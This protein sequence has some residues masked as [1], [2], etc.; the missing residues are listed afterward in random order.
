MVH[1]RKRPNLRQKL[2]ILAE[3]AQYD[4][5]LSSCNTGATGER[6]RVRDPN[7][8]LSK[9]IYPAAV[10]GKGTVY[11]LKVLQT[12]VC[13]NNCSYCG[14]AAN[15]DRHERMTL[16]PEELAAGFMMLHR[17]KKVGG[18]FLSSGVC[19]SP[20]SSMDSMIRT[21]EILRERYKFKDYLHLKIL[22]GA[23]F[24]VVEAAVRLAN[25]VSIN[26]E[27][28]TREQLGKIAPG[29]SFAEDLV[30]RMKWA[31]EMIRNGAKAKTQTT[32]FVVG[33]AGESDLDI[34]RTTDWLYREIYLFRTYFSAYQSLETPDLAE[35][36]KKSVLLREHRL[37]QTDFLL[38]GY[39][40]RLPDLIFDHNGDLPDHV[41]PK[42]AYAMMHPELFPIDINGADEEEL[43]KVPG[44]GPISARRICESRVAQPFH[45]V[46]E[47]RGLG[48]IAKR[49]QP[50]LTFS[51]TFRGQ[52]GLFDR[53]P[54]KT[55]RS[56]VE[57]MVVNDDMPFVP[58]NPGVP[59]PETNRYTYPGQTGR[60]LNY[61]LGK[62]ESEVLCR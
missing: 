2:E 46:E 3:S 17:S 48:V 22:P 28:P 44:I 50:Y 52:L 11:I 10:P 24:A 26:I 14:F 35:V 56:G 30:T 33:A 45:H 7:A 41:D 21:S 55:W 42:M 59:D 6:G 38:R 9:W 25:R 62:K 54:P 16:S 23:S 40:F 19:G 15:R 29:K 18:L 60:R 4:V 37:Y 51:G 53:E 47:L 49:A 1:V 43:L 12:N 58:N 13:K 39:G 5:C 32:Q 61:S 31:G 8:Y 34:M 20:D 36:P 57:P 27:A